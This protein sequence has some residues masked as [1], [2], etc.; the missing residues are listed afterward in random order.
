[1]LVS[2]P[3]AFLPVQSLCVQ[4]F[5]RPE[6]KMSEFGVRKGLLIKKVPTEK[7]GDPLVPQIHLKKIQNSA[8]FYIK[9]DGKQEGQKMIDDHRH[10]GANRGLRK[11]VLSLF[12]LVDMSPVT[13][14]L[15][16]FDKQYIPYS[17]GE[18]L[19]W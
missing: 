18:A 6:L 17:S 12:T 16:I 15:Q 13:R 8:F 19:F 7:M 2:S 10:L 1:M 11:I 5:E 3:D 4:C 9:R 14:F